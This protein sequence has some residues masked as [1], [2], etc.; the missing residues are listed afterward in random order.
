MTH[1]PRIR[2][3]VLAAALC[4][5]VVA[6]AGVKPVA[7][8]GTPEQRQACTPEVFRLCNDAVPDVG[9]ITACLERNRTRLNVECRRAMASGGAEPR[10]YYSRR[11]VRRH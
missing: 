2:T 5:S 6:V 4:F 10:P 7:A 11:H 1:R 8:Q 9:R 3:A